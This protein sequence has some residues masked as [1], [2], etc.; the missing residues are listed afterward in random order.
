MFDADDSNFVGIRA[1]TVAQAA[2]YVIVLPG[3]VPV[4][5]ELLRVASVSGSNVNLE[6]AALPRVW[7]GQATVVGTTGSWSVTVPAGVFTANPIA[8]AS[9][10]APAASQAVNL[11]GSTITSATT[12]TITGQAYRGRQTTVVLGGSVIGTAYAPAG[13]VVNVIAVQYP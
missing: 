9:I 11:G 13:T 7:A 3:D 8:N 6:Y 1:P 12:T 4:A 5:N 10:I 2:N